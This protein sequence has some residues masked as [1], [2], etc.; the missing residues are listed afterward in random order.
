MDPHFVV[1]MATDDVAGNR[2]QALPPMDAMAAPGPMPMG[3]LNTV[4]S[5]GTGAADNQGLTLVP[6]SAEPELFCP[7][8]NPT[9]LMN[10]SRSCSG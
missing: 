2:W 5:V 10:V 9:S 6:I 1:Q 8:Y 7:P 3:P 4:G